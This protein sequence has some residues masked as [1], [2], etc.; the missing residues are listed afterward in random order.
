MSI[1]CFGRKGYFPMI[2]YGS[3]WR[4]NGVSRKSSLDIAGEANSCLVLNSL[5]EINHKICVY[6]TITTNNEISIEVHFILITLTSVKKC[7]LRANFSSNINSMIK[8]TSIRISLTNKKVRV[9][10]V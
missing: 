7:P 6:K 1:L 4:R 10:F 5:V 2:L 9:C 8:L 3:T